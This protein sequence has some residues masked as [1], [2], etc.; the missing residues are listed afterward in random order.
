[1]ESRESLVRRAL[2]LSVATVAWN[3]IAGGT[4]LALALSMGSLALLGFGF[5]AVVDSVASIALVWRFA[6]EH[7][8]PQRAIRV[9]R[10]AAAVVGAVLVVLGLY[11]AVASVRAL[12]DHAGHDASLPA[13]ALLVASA[14]VLPPLGVAKLRT[15]RQL[16]SL[17]LRGDSILTLV[18]ALLAVVGLVSAL[19]S[20]TAGMWWADPFGGLLVSLVLLREGVSGLADVRAGSAKGRATL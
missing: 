3:G 15:A 7:A 14:L 20:Q 10:V 5:D 2:L 17:A 18:A 1:M 8:Q 16:D 6:A 4:A 9:E 12:I 13:V 19:L 11:L